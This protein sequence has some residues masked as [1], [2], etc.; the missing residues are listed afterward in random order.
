MNYEG[1]TLGDALGTHVDEAG[2][3]ELTEEYLLMVHGGATSNPPPPPPPEDRWQ[4][5]YD[6]ADKL[7]LFLD[8]K[9]GARVLVPFITDVIVPPKPTA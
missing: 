7:I 1:T 5:V 8:Q 9:F 6:A 2:V 4:R 3:L